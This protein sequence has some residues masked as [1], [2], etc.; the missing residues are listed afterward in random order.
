MT[1]QI[2]L[3]IP[4]AGLGSRFAQAGYKVLKP[5]IPIHG[6]PM[7]SVV[8]SNLMDPRIGHIVL[9]CQ[10]ATMEN[11]DLRSIINPG[12]AQLTILAVDEITDGP[13]GTLEVARP[14]LDMN[15]PLVVANSDQYLDSQLNDF[16]DDLSTGTYDGEIL[17]MRDSDPKWSFARV[18]D[19]GLLLELREKVVI[20]DLATVGIYGYARADLAFDAIAKMREARDTTNGEYYVGPAYNYLVESG[21]RVFVRDLGPVSTVMYGLGIPKDLDIFL[22]T[23]LSLLAAEKAMH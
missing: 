13:A 22:N 23:K 16:Y 9:V 17:A 15:L 6:A 12:P 20:S 14:A 7:I 18:N 4:M 8:T 5:L 10:R 19:D 2:Q 21:K 3:V 11:L 1:K